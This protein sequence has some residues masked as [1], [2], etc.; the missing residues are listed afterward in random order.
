MGTGM[1]I[2]MIT[3]SPYSL[4]MPAGRIKRIPLVTNHTLPRFDGNKKQ[5]VEQVELSLPEEATR[6]V[7]Q[8]YYHKGKCD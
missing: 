5:D 1:V 4:N 2:M 6:G 3:T 7:F 8:S